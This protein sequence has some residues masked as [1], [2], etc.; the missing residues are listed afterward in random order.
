METQAEEIAKSLGYKTHARMIWSKDGM[1]IPAAF[2]IRYSHEYLLYMYRGKLIPIAKNERGKIADV[3][4]EKPHRHSEKPEVSF[5]II[6][7]LYPNLS[8]LELYARKERSN[9]DCWGNEV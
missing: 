4:V 1:G 7:R 8:K 6:E 9:W 5:E 2:T 3:F